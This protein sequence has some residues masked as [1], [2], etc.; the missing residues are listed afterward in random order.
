[1]VVATAGSLAAQLVALTAASRDVSMAALWAETRA[2]N[3]AAGKVADSAGT[4][5]A[6]T[7]GRTADRWAV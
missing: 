3:S 1:M 2:E 4:R 6:V 5:A 7:D